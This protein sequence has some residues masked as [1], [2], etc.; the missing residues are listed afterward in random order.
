MLSAQHAISAKWSSGLRET[1]GK[2]EC[3]SGRLPT[4]R[5]EDRAEST[6]IQ[7]SRLADLEHCFLER[8]PNVQR[9]SL[10]LPKKSDLWLVFANYYL[11]KKQ[12]ALCMGKKRLQGD[13]NAQRRTSSRCHTG[14]MTATKPNFCRSDV[15]QNR[16]QFS[17]LC[18]DQTWGIKFRNEQGSFLL[19]KGSKM[20]TVSTTKSMVHMALVTS[21]G[22]V[23]ELE[24]G[25]LCP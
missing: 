5:P 24:P 13:Y 25:L 9:V 19:K 1:I 10:S 23:C 21:G 2:R 14:G 16:T 12:F 20:L 4:L 15:A 8:F 11:I 18:H 17:M 6:N 7:R 22:G 3:G